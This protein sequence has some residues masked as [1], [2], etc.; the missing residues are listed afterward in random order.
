LRREKNMEYQTHELPNGIKLI[1]KQTESLIAHAGLF[2]NADQE[3]SALKSMA[4]HTLLSICFLKALRNE[5][6]I[7]S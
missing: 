3:M 4:L 2:I 6:L 7:I 1:H 5:K